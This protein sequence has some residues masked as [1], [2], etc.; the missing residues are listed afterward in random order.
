MGDRQSEMNR[1][2][3]TTSASNILTRLASRSITGHTHPF[4]CT[5]IMVWNFI[6]F[7]PT[8]HHVFVGFATL[9][10]THSSS[11]HSSKGNWRVSVHVCLPRNVCCTCRTRLNS[12]LGHTCYPTCF[13]YP[14][15]KTNATF[16]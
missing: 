13:G 10:K 14:V 15:A 11:V 8:I 4:R 3:Q 5:N 12:V 16:V 9:V 6:S 7:L 2:L 1:N